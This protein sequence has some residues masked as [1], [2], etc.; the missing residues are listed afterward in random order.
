MSCLT[1]RSNIQSAVL[2]TVGYIN[3]LINSDAHVN[4]AISEVIKLMIM[5]VE[6][7]SWQSVN[8]LSLLSLVLPIIYKRIQSIYMDWMDKDVTKRISLPRQV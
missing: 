8:I 2:A 5:D 6:K 1:F 7:K 4:N 3:K